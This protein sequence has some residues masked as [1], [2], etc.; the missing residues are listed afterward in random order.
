MKGKNTM[1]SSK[2][3]GITGMPLA[4]KTLAAE[5][6]EEKGFSVVD[7]GDVVR[8]EME[9]RDIPTEEVADFVNGQRDKKGMGA[10]AELTV[11][12]LKESLEESNVVITGM[13][14]WSEK[15]VFESHIDEDILM[16]AL[17]ASR[18]TRK[19]RR[20]E[21]KREEDIKGQDFHERDLREIDN[22]IAK[23]MALSDVMIVNDG[24]SIDELEEK[25]EKK[26][27]RR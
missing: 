4:G 9:K 21:R 1:Y 24:I 14:G 5:I 27:L 20:E 23:L 10:I 13:R 2:V 11:P 18:E 22:G 8:K 7:M 3:V 25:I 12:Y 16:V 6:L 26:V 19:N 17:W 15:K